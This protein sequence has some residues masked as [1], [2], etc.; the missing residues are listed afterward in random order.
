MSN[1]KLFGFMN[2]TFYSTDAI[3]FVVVPQNAD[4]KTNAIQT[5]VHPELNQCEID[6]YQYHTDLITECNAQRVAFMKEFLINEK[7][8]DIKELNHDF[9][10]EVDYDLYNKDGKVIKSG[11]SGINT[12]ICN[13]LINSDINENNSLEYRKAFVFDGRLEINTPTISRYGIKNVYTQH[14]YTLKIN[15][16]VVK[17]TIGDYKYITESDSQLDKNGILSENHAHYYHSRPADLHF[18]NF[19][20]H[21][22]TNKIGTTV[23]DQLVVPAELEAPVEYEEIPVCEIVPSESNIIKVNEKI[24]VFVINVEI[25]L[26]NFNEVFDIADITSIL[27]LNNQPEEIPSDTENPDDSENN[28]D[29]TED[30]QTPSDTEIPSEGE[31]IDTT[32][33]IQ[34]PS[35]EGE[36]TTNEAIDNSSEGTPSETNA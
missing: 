14:P 35:E 26:D 9:I 18:N 7:I 22:I 33:D 28:S 23:I 2:N 15:K 21:F 3:Q 32:E 19:A 30:N 25:V 1:N 5:T 36:D 16:I 10:I 34:T 29:T 6:I 27:D 4:Y 24:N 20:S 8:K 12:K 31:D 13:A 11:S 17:S